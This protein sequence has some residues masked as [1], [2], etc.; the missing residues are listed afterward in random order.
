MKNLSFSEKN[1]FIVK[2][3]SGNCFSKDLELFKK[4]F[5]IH[6][7]NNELARANSFTY[8]RL[9]GQMLYALLENISPEEILENR[10]EKRVEG[11][12]NAI[13]ESIDQAKESETTETVTEN[14]TIQ[15]TESTQ[16]G[17]SAENLKVFE[18][19]TF[20]K[21]KVNKKNSPQ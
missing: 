3:K 17:S 19:K 9:D 8:D 10:E 16:E 2:Y 15:E 21:K 1:N 4:Y 12:V 20:N 13:I 18:E 5:P 7:L 11:Q 14:P 6:K